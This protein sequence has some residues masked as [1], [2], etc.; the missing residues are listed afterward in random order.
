MAALQF[1][2]VVHQLLAHFQR[3]FEQAFVLDDPHVFKRCGRSGRAAAEG[4]DV[5]EIGHRVGW[6]VLEQ[7]EDLFGR[8]RA[9]DRCVTR[10]D[11]LRHGDEIG[12]D[13]VVLVTEPFTGSA[14][15]ADDFVDMQQNIVFAADFLH[16]FPITLGRGDDAAAGS[17]RFQAEKT[18][19]FRAFAQDD[20]FDRVRCA[21]AVIVHV[22]PLAAI[23]EAVRHLDKTVRHRAVLFAALLL[24]GCGERAERRA[25]VIAVA[26]EDLVFAA[27]VLP[28]RDL[29]HHLE[30]LLVRFRA[31]VRIIDAGH[32]RHLF[33]QLFSEKRCRN[34]ACCAGEIVELYQLVSHRIGNRCSAITDIDGP[35]GTGDRIEIFLAGRIPDPRAL[36]LDIDFWIDALILLVLREM[37]PDMGAVGL[38]DGLDVVRTGSD[39]HDVP[40]SVL[41]AVQAL[42][43]EH[44]GIS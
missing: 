40:L 39:V 9:G 15:A 33:D 31:G 30:H 25:V 14:H 37:V 23:F 19:G 27:I 35:D 2:Q 41:C 43:S 32:A 38:D 12:L 11:A 6:I 13:T 20:F 10:G 17:D 16:A 21:D 22:T 1:A 4:G 3:V 44:G 42:S 24:A 34:V 28:V 29:A 18:N 26:V 36:A 5:A 7:F 8:H